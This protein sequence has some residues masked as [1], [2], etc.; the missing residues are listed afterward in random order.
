MPAVEYPATDRF[1]D[2][3]VDPE[4]DE[5]LGDLATEMGEVLRGTRL[6]P[7]R[8]TLQ[9]FL[10]LYPREQRLIVGAAGSGMVVEAAAHRMLAG[11]LPGGAR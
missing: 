1:A 7:A 4:P 2:Y 9:W 3:A 8:A 10:C 6:A 11:Y 5:A